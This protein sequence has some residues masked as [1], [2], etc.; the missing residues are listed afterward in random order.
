[1][2]V[3]DHLRTELVVA[4]RARDTP[5]VSALRACLAALANAEAVPAEA[6]TLDTGSEHV[7]GAAAGLGASE[8]GRQELS[9]AQQ[10]EIVVQ[11][12]DDLTEHARRLQEAGRSADAA[13]AVRSARLLTDVLQRSAAG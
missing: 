3:T 9:E 6:T 10:R 12:A 2:T 7:A 4:L 8:A 13:D 5:V 1:M 11:E